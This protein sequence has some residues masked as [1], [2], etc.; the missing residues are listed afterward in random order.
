LVLN[1]VLAVFDTQRSIARVGYS[2]EYHRVV[3]NGVPES[4]SSITGFHYSTEYP[5]H[6]YLPPF[7]ATQRSILLLSSRRPRPNAAVPIISSSDGL[8]VSPCHHLILPSWISSSW[9]LNAVSPSSSLLGYYQ[10]Y[11]SRQLH[12][13]FLS[14][15][16]YNLIILDR[17]RPSYIFLFPLSSGTLQIITVDASSCEHGPRSRKVLE[18]N[19]PTAVNLDLH[20]GPPAFL[21]V[22]RLRVLL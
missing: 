1:G 3:L 2:T 22:P 6:Y 18:S 10:H 12:A 14:F 4:S 9:I 5:N 15:I 13:A 20:Y 17:T 8:Q 16:I 11:S 21:A 7:F 19:I